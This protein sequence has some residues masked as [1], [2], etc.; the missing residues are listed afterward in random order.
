M[1]KSDRPLQIRLTEPVIFLRGPST[2][3]DFRGRPQVVRQD[4]PPA[5]LRGLLTLRLNKATRIR[6]I[7]IKL[8]GK[9]RTEWPEGEDLP[10]YAQHS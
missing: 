7:D 8:E 4:A 3:Y 2:G 10:P 5:M 1:V 9:A 6:K